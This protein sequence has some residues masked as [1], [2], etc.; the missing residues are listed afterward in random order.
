MASEISLLELE[1]CIGVRGM[2]PNSC[3]MHPATDNIYITCLGSHVVV[4]DVYDPH[5]QKFLRGHDADVTAL[6]VSPSGR[7]V[8]SGQSRSPNAPVREPSDLLHR[9]LIDS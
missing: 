8:A 6:D 1:H 4:N 3:L 5:N 7:F 2:R 9:S